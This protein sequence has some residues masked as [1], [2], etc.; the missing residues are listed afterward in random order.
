MPMQVEFKD[1]LPAL[2]APRLGG[3]LTLQA[4]AGPAIANDEFRRSQGPAGSKSPN[5]GV[6]CPC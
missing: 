6:T 4:I 2:F 3:H 1:P 5:V